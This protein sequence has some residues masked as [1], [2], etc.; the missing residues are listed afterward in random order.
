MQCACAMLS[1][2]ACPAVQYFYTLSHKQY[3]IRKKL[4]TTKYV[5]RLSL[6]NLSEPFLI[7]S[8]TE[9]DMIINVSW[10][11]GTEPVILVR[12]K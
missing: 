8:R 11:S 7:L 12:I 4:L 2:V 1:S 5:F 10:S 9:R 6:Q 3:E